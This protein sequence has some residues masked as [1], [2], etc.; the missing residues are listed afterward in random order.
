MGDPF[1]MYRKD[2]ATRRKVVRIGASVSRAVQSGSRP[3]DTAR[4]G[5]EILIKRSA[6]GLENRLRLWRDLSGDGAAVP[7]PTDDSILRGG[8]ALV[9][10]GHA[11]VYH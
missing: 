9:M 10:N 1:T 11:S 8:V 4:P 5:G 3:V 2:S 6:V 7:M